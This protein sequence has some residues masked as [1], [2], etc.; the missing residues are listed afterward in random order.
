MAKH[1]GGEENRKN[2]FEYSLARLRPEDIEVRL[3][4][5]VQEIAA[6]K[7]NRLMRLVVLILSVCLFVG[8]FAYIVFKVT[9]YRKSEAFYEGLIED[10]ENG[11]RALARDPGDMPTAAFGTVDGRGNA[12]YNQLFSR[13]KARLVSMQDINPDVCGWI[14]IPGTK[15]INYPILQ[16][17][18]NEYYLD[19]EFK[20]GY[21][22]AGSIFVDYTCDRD[23][24][25]NHN[26][27]IYGHNMQNGMMFSELISFLDEEFFKNNKYVYVYTMQGVYTYEVF[28]VYKTNYLYK[29]TQTSFP[30]HTDFVAFANEMRDNSM[31]RRDGIEFDENSRII[32]L[33]TCTNGQRTDRYCVQALLVDAYNE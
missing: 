8:S 30:T 31:F 14:I 19:H 12:S 7:R 10:F 22:N 28:A 6:E 33:S 5:D 32:T 9:Q 15:H 17:T 20:G 3:A 16:S 26:T 23:F 24:N 18:D 2:T 13:M 25:G 29:Y 11:E 27:V 4:R 21:L 1:A